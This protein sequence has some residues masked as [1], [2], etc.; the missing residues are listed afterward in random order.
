MASSIQ[1]TI[2]TAARGMVGWGYIYGATGWVCTAARVE[3][4]AAQ[5]PAYADL[6]RKYGFGKWLGKRCVDCAQNTKIS[7]K[8]A[9]ITIPSGAT[10]QWNA[11]IWADKG[12]MDTLPDDN[13]GL[14]LYRQSGSKM[15]HTGVCLG[16]G[17]VSE[18]RGHAYGVIRSQLAA[19]GWT[20]WGRLDESRA[21]ATTATTATTTTETEGVNQM[22]TLAGYLCTVS[23]L[24]TGTSKLNIRSSM[25]D[26]AN[27]KIGTVTF[28]EQVTC[29]ADTGTWATIKTATGVVGY[30]KSQY[31]TAVSKADS[32]DIDRLTLLEERVTA[33]E[34]KVLGINKA[35]SAA[36]TE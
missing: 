7:A 13:V 28:G 6:I 2:A 15:Q 8:A 33:L 19:Y 34:V 17:T 27:N 30:C 4:Q 12:T 18:A 10:S 22:S 9:G 3:Q 31:L 25:D 20:H 1:K 35:A 21:A 32:S 16:D 5:Y 23:G 11:D 29:T 24:K 36:D 14:F 26:T